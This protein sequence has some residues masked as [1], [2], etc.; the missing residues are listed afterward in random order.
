MKRWV[1]NVG[2]TLLALHVSACDRDD[3]KIAV[4]AAPAA[5]IALHFSAPADLAACSRTLL[6]V[7]GKGEC[8]NFETTRQFALARRQPGCISGGIGTCDSYRFVEK[9]SGF[10]ALQAYF[11]SSG[12]LIALSV[13]NDSS[14]ECVS[15]TLPTCAKNFTERICP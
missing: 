1:E 3:R 8:A 15:G 9:D 13:R 5:S 6:E 4:R 14:G 11:G 2:F 12:A 10:D 7:C